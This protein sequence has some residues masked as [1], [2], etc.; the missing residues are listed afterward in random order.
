MSMNFTVS[1]QE[2]LDLLEKNR[3]THHSIFLAAQEKFREKVIEA[4]EERLALAREGK[5]VNLFVSLPEPEEHTEDYDNAISALKMHVDDTIDLDQQAYNTLVLNQWAWA[6]AF[7]S[8]TS[9]Y[10][11]T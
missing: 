9:S 7:A 5:K 2:L 10:L 4:F 3:D 8:N 11:V 1:K 6:R